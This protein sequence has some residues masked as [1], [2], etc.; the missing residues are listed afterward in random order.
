MHKQDYPITEKTLRQLA[1]NIQSPIDKNSNITLLFKPEFGGATTLIRLMLANKSELNF[2]DSSKYKVCYLETT[3]LHEQS[4]LAFFYKMLSLVN[5]ESKLD[6]Y[7]N[8]SLLNVL[9]I[10][11][12][13]LKKI[14]KSKT[15][16]FVFTRLQ[17]FGQF[18]YDY[19]NILYSL[20]DQYELKTKLFFVFTF[21]DSETL[22][23]KD[24]LE[25]QKLLKRSLTDTIVNIKAL[26]ENDI[27]HSINFWEVSFGHKISD[28]HKK[29]ISELSQGYP[30]A[31]KLLCREVSINPSF[32]KLDL[33]A[34]L[35]M[36]FPKSVYNKMSF[37]KNNLI[38]GDDFN[39]SSHFTFLE[40]EILRLFAS[41]E[42]NSVITKD[43][44]AE[45]IWQ[46]DYLNLY[47]DQT[48][49]K[50]ISNIRKKLKQLGYCG[51][52]SSKKG[53]GYYITAVQ[54]NS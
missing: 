30:Y 27:A 46:E 35:G 9:Q 53:F 49:D 42:E 31:I 12:N 13:E 20:R 41:R 11:R 43:E 8:L 16:I 17:E 26:G 3:E 45:I 5:S 24:F 40:N 36:K 48:I 38:L 2:F 54:K 23:F 50:H 33:K 6:D 44:L 18:D 34:Y 52:I 21:Y 37:I 28:G 39:A 19:G 10:L 25:N 15:L 7:D 14:C 29:I 47:S 4:K 1:S 51:E 22:P 32:T